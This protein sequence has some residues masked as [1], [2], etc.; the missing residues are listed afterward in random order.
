MEGELIELIMARHLASLSSSHHLRYISKEDL[1]AGLWAG[2]PRPSNPANTLHQMIH[3]L[4]AKLNMPDWLVSSRKLGWATNLDWGYEWRC[5]NPRI[6][7]IR[8]RY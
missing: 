1:I 2:R 3:K 6:M 4:R 5:L 7:G 8:P